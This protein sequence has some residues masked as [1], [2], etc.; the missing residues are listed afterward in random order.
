MIT[1]F[2]TYTT[3]FTSIFGDGLE[4]RYLAKKSR[5]EKKRRKKAAERPGKPEKKPVAALEDI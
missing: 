4:S 2:F 1:V 3:A 5:E